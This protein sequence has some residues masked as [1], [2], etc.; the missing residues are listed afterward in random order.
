MT[1]EGSLERLF[2]QV[3]R[4]PRRL[5]TLPPPTRQLCYRLGRRYATLGQWYQAL[6]G[7]PAWEQLPQREQDM[8]LGGAKLAH[9]QAQRLLW[10]L[11]RVDRALWGLDFR[12]MLLKGAAYL[13]D[14]HAFARGRWVGDLDLLFAEEHLPAAERALL[15]HG[16]EF[17]H[18]TPQDQRYYRQLTHELPPLVHRHRG[19]ELDLH[20]AISHPLGPWPVSGS[21][22]LA[23]GR[24]LPHWP[25]WTLPTHADLALH[26]VLHLFADADFTQPRGPRDMLDLAALLESC[27]AM[28]GF[29]EDL[30][31]RAAQWRVEIPLALALA[32]LEWAGISPVPPQ[33]RAMLPEQRSWRTFAVRHALQ[34]ALTPR[35]E[36]VNGTIPAWAALGL[37]LRGLRLRLPPGRLVSHLWS[38]WRRGGWG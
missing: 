13:L 22:L 23:A 10:E 4:D 3:G 19:G 28:P 15:A 1:A 9:A 31:R 21:S 38:K 12:P 35:L 29:W 33:S 24:P 26:A 34:A 8:L 32:T 36:D 30:A 27:A 37:R 2:W 17:V 18:T 5:P 25:G 14:G 11:D 6:Q 16:W 7:H 20:R